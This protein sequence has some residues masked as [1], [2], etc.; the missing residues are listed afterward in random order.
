MKFRIHGILESFAHGESFEVMIPEKDNF[1]HYSTNLAMRI[2]Q[3]ETSG[4]RQ[5]TSKRGVIELA[6]ELV[7]KISVKAPKGMFEKVEVA[8]PGFINFWLSKEFLQKELGD[9][10][11]NRNRYGKNDIGR[12]K[13][14]VIE[15]SSPNIAKPL[16][17]HHIRT[18]II[19]QTLVNILRFVGYKIISLSFPGDWGTQFGLLIAGYKKWGDSKKM[20]KD[21]MGEMLRLYVKFSAAAKEDPKLLDEGREEFRKL[22]EGNKENLKLWKWFSDESLKDF[23]RVYKLLDVQIE[24]TIGESFYERELGGLVQDALRR[25]IAKKGEDGSVTLMIPG[26]ETPEI[27]QKSDGATIYTTRELAAIRHRF[28]KWKADKILYVAANQQTFH[29]SQVFRSAELLGYARPGQLAHVKFGMVLAPGG[30]KFATREGKLVP[31]EEVISKVIDLA[32]KKVSDK[33]PDLSEENKR[34]VARVVGVGALKYYDL[35]ENRNSD[36][37]FDWERMLDLR[38]NSAPYL[39]YTYARLASILQKSRLQTVKGKSKVS[40]GLLDKKEELDLIRKI[41]EFPDVVLEAHESL[42][43]S[44]FC[45]YLYELCNLANRFY[46]AT[47]VIKESNLTLRGARLKL[48]EMTNQVLGKGLGLLGIKVLDKI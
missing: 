15:Y 25:K 30:K 8:G 31:M 6:K 20:K 11:E 42:L 46:E 40:F 44:N 43:T 1:G 28:E 12:S 23:E 24:N 26:S 37:V 33:N 38:G 36:I 10:Y 17:I 41:L 14:W 39:Q 35:K 21:P 19:G 5:E 32:Y 18:T 13:T 7:A 3:R 9:V 16:G 34:A 4:K 2:A 47:P 22:E 29:L 48:V 27:I 45:N